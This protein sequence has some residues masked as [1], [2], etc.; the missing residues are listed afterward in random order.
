MQNSCIFFSQCVCNNAELSG[1]LF[2]FNFVKTKAIK[3]DDIEMGLKR[4]AEQ[5]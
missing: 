2:Q 1:F 4:G 3:G 5:K